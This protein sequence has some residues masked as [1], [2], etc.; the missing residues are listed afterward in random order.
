VP[1]ALKLW[2]HTRLNGGLAAP[3]IDPSASPGG[4]TSPDAGGLTNQ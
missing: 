4:R 1:I 3:S 2:Q